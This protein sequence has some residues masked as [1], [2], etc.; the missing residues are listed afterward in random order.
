MSR[1]FGPSVNSRTPYEASAVRF[2]CMLLRVH[3]GP[4][5]V[6]SEPTTHKPRSRL[7][8][9]N[10]GAYVVSPGPMLRAKSPGRWRIGSG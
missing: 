4:I 3:P 9:T 8:K 10:C 1:T 6:A 5:R 2:M 7:P